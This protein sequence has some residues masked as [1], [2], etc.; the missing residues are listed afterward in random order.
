MAAARRHRHS[1]RPSQRVAGPAA[2]GCRLWT[3]PRST[4]YLM[5]SPPTSDRTLD[6]P[7]AARVSASP[8]LLDWLRGLVSLACVLLLPMLIIGTSVRAVFSDRAFMLQGF[9]DNQV[10][11]TTGLDDAQLQR[12]ADA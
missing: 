11:V 10:G 3:P 7:V 12:I 4:R 8:D 5:R 1:V 9:R 6:K 2:A